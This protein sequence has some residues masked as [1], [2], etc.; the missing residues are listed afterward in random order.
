V[1]TARPYILD[2]ADL[3]RRLIAAGLVCSSMSLTRQSTS[4]VDGYAP[5]GEMMSELR[6]FDSII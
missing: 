4:G 2:V 1:S 3:K 5:V 6:T